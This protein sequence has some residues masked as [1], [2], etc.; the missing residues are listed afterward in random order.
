LKGF[1]ITK[2][3]DGN[4]FL[5]RTTDFNNHHWPNVFLLLLEMLKGDFQ[6]PIIIQPSF[7]SVGPAGRQVKLR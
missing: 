2:S 1:A 6:T 5:A 7:I 3:T 4:G